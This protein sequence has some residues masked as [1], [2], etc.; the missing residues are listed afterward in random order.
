MNIRNCLKYILFICSLLF[1]SGCSNYDLEDAKSTVAKSGSKNLI[2]A[3]RKLQKYK[4]GSLPVENWPKI[5]S[6]LN[7]EEIYVTDDGVNIVMYRRFVEEHGIYILF[8]G[9]KPLELG[10]TDPVFEIIEKDVYWYLVAG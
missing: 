2:E 5:L 1:V 3:A 7:P 4:Q 6:D 9:L 8:P 10:G